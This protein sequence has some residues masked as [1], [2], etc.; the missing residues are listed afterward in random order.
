MDIK[1]KFAKKIPSDSNLLVLCNKDT[2]WEAYLETDKEIEYVK[3]SLK[4]DIKQ[5]YVNQFKRYVIFEKTQNNNQDTVKEKEKMRKQ[6]HI[7]HTFID[8][9][10]IADICLVDTTGCPE[11]LLAF[12]EG[13]ALSAYRFLPHFQKEE[14]KPSP[15][16]KIT[17]ASDSIESKQTE[18][19]QNLIEGVYHTRNLVNHPYSYLSTE[20]FVKEIKQLSDASGFSV[21]ILD[22]RRIESL[23]MHGLLSVNKGSSAP[24]AFAILQWKPQDAKNNRPLVLVGKGVV[25]DSGG[26]S[27]KPTL[28]SMD[29][30]KCDMAGAATVTGCMYA[31]AKNNLPVYTIGLLPITDNLPGKNAY[32]PGDVIQTHSGA[33]VEVMN[34]DAEG[35]IIMADA[36]SYAKK[37]NPDLVIDIATLT[38]AAERA[39]G[40]DAI[41]AMG[42]ADK[43]TWKTMKQIGF[44]AHER[45]IELPLWE[46]YGE[47]IKSDIADIKNI[48]G[49]F[50]G[51]I[52]AGKFLEYF[53]DYPWIHLDFAGPAFITSADSY[54]GKG[55]TGTGVRLLYNFIKKRY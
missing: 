40:K 29:I 13:L 30:M 25:Y 38:G 28:N 52:T 16:Q 1:I 17:I 39:F 14:K 11:I 41:A 12:C 51:A 3:Q 46:E 35:R 7:L 8:T 23:K 18:E 47:M 4:F 44:D 32:N 36:L 33:T 22:K 37:Y 43:D 27:L 19:L 53:T 10:K 26:L 21:E 5:I 55:S 34:T 42:T 24:P 45:I 6:A 50:A 2:N 49:K 31:L 15:L 48:G 20:Q 9:N 54:R